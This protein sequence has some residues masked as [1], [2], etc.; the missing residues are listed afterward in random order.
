MSCPVAGG[1][2][3]PGALASRVSATS[4]VVRRS[5]A[6]WAC[7]A[8]VSLL[9][10]GACD[11]GLL[12]VDADGRTLRF[13]GEA[14]D[15][16]NLTLSD[17]QGSVWAVEDGARLSAGAGCKVGADPYS[18]VCH[19]AGIDRLVIDLGGLGS[20]LQ[21]LTRLPTVVR[22]SPYDDV[23][24]AGPG[25][26]TIDTGAG[27]NVVTIAGPGR[28]LIRAGNGANVISYAS[29]LDVRGGLVPRRSGVRIVL[30]RRGASGGVGQRDTLLGHYSEVDGS[31]TGNDLID[32]R[33]G[34]P[35]TVVC[36]SGRD[37]VR[38]D[39]LDT[40][41]MTCR[42]VHVAPA[43]GMASM[44]SAPLPFPFAAAPQARSQIIADQ[45]IALAGGA[46][47]VR[48]T[49]PV[50]AGLLEIFGPGC[51]GRLT[52]AR[53]RLVLATRRLA[54]SR[55]ATLTWNVP[56]PA[57]LRSLAA[58]PAGLALHASA[59]ATRDA[60]RTTSFTVHTATPAPR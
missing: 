6:I 26:E 35:Q 54:L 22:G 59:T 57:P 55:G 1:S 44:R 23:I 17:R 46:V 9:A 8:G 40:P 24:V 21:L 33:D 25:D 45:P 27:A 11:A 31:S 2:W 49:C 14:L 53:D 52:L 58:R 30:G 56:L 15:A 16:N 19:A 37:T 60:T 32:V 29:Q 7:V 3:S 50:P 12:G 34:T 5:V 51:R 13:A 47:L 28:H 43:A 18:A 39:P 4:R 38:V 41:Q 48:V 42:T 36:G 10:A 20:D